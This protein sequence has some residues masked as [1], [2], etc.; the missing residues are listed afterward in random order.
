M[1]RIPNRSRQA[2]QLFEALLSHSTSWQ[3]GYDLSKV[4]GLKS[5][6]LYPLLMRLCEQG[7]LEDRWEDSDIAGRPPRHAYRLTP[8]GRAFAREALSPPE[9]RGRRVRAARST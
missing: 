2:L 9:P 5:G 7:L 6:T 1:P 8:Q 4:T 3:H